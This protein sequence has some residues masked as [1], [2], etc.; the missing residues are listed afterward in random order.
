MSFVIWVLTANDCRR[1]PEPLLSRCPPVRLQD[2]SLTDLVGFPR[3]EGH[4][5]G[6]DTMSIDAIVEVLRRCSQQS[7]ISLRTV[8]RMIEKAIM[9]QEGPEVAH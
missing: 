1:L 2:L 4:R 7:R 6:L 8:S 9:L 3:R 5:R